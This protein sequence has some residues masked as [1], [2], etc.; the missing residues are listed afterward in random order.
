MPKAKE[1]KVK[2]NFS[3]REGSRTKFYPFGPTKGFKEFTTK[4]MAQKACKVQKQLAKTGHAPK[5]YGKVMQITITDSS[6]ANARTSRWGY[7]TQRAKRLGCPRSDIG[8]ECTRCIR[9]ENK[10]SEDMNAIENSIYKEHDLYCEDRH[11]GN[12]GLINGK[13]VLIDCG[14]ETFDIAYI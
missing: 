1:I 5:V 12:Y 4:E 8:C 2:D 14:C 9:D 3:C 7:F 6:G 10:Y 13:I 11:L